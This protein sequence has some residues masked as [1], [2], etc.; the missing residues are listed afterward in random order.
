MSTGQRAAFLWLKLSAEITD[1]TV[2]KYYK[3][4]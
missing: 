3:V 1:A 2:L 4:G